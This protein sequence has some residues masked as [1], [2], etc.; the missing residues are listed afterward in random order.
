[1]AHWGD[2]P[3]I[4]AGPARRKDDESGL[5]TYPAGTDSSAGGAVRMDGTM[6]ATIAELERMEGVAVTYDDS[7]IDADLTDGTNTIALPY[8]AEWFHTLLSERVAPNTPETLAAS[9]RL[10][11]ADLC[12][13]PAGTIVLPFRHTLGA[14]LE[15]QCAG[16]AG[17]ARS[18]AGLTI[19]A[20]RSFT[21]IP[22]ADDPLLA[23]AATDASGFVS[24]PIP[25]GSVA[26][27]RFTAYLAEAP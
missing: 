3:L 5:F 25:V 18:G 13:T 1:M 22:A 4:G 9:L 10:T 23:T 16:P 24:V 15:A 6:A 26:G 11:G 21:G 27:N 2:N 17:T 14:V 7:A 20:R 8:E 19:E 12:A